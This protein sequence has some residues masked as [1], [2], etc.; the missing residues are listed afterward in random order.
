MTFFHGL[1]VVVS[2]QIGSGIFAAPT[3][4]SQHTNSAAVAVFVWLV[5]GLLVW[6]GASSFIELG[7]RIPRN[8]GVQEYLRHCYG[9]FLGFLFTWTWVTIS[10]ASAMAIITGVF[11]QYFCRAMLGFAD[12]PYLLIKIVGL[13]GLWLMTAVNC[14]GART[15]ANVANAFFLLKLC[16]LSSIIFVGFGSWILSRRNETPIIM[17]QAVFSAQGEEES[18]FNKVDNTVTA[19]FGAL[20]CYGGWETVS[21]NHPSKY[22]FRSLT[23]AIRIPDWIYSWGY[24]TS[25]SR[26][27]PRS[28]YSNVYCNHWF[29]HDEY[30]AVSCSAYRHRS[31]DNNADNCKLIF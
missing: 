5:A 1:S 18:W 20:F 7:I 24:G 2:L 16:A 4:V 25:N 31:H 23:K 14:L 30:F 22:P 11:A 26:F 21:F 12:P 3:Q 15:G 29:R 8:G 10:K 28:A 9:D 13:A 17:P 19:I 27:A 6:T